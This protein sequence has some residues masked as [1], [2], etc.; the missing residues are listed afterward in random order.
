MPR[1]KGSK[2]KAT[3]LREADLARACKK[4]TGYLATY[5]E[6]VLKAVVS[7][8]LEGDMT[9]AK[10]ILDRTLPARRAIE[11]LPNRSMAIQINI[12]PT[13]IEHGQISQERLQ[14]PRTL[15]HEHS[16][17]QAGERRQGVQVLPLN[18]GSSGQ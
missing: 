8:A 9:A 3:L 13:E 6:P 17:G 4:G 12:T 18:G 7:R 14:E 5:L 15:E 1:P 10:L 16:S 2:N 11:D